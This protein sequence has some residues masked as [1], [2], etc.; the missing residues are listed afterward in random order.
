MPELPTGTVTFLFT[1][2][3]GSTKLW[4]EHP[5]AMR[6]VLAQHDTL[7][8]SCIESYG[9]HVFKTIG[10]AFCAVF[11]EPAGA[12]M[13]AIAAQQWLSALSLP[14]DG[15]GAPLKVRMALHSGV[16]E[17]RDGDYFGPVLNRIARLLALAHGGQVLL[18]EAA[19][20][21]VRDGLPPA[22]VLEPLGEHRLKDLGRPESI[23]Q[24]CHPDLQAGVLLLRSSSGVIRN[25]PQQP[26]AFVGREAEV[27]EWSREIRKRSHRLFT[28]VGL[29]GVGKTRVAVRLGESLAQEFPDGVWWCGL[30]DAADAH[31]AAEHLARALGVPLQPEPA[32]LAQVVRHLQGRQALLILDNVEQ[33]RG[34]PGLLKTLLAESRQLV[35]LVTSRR[36]LELRGETVLELAPMN[37]D[38]SVA[39]FRERASERRPDFELD[40][41]NEKDVRELCRRLEG[42]PLAIELAAARVGGMT[43]RQILQRLTERFRLLQS[44]SEEMNERQRALRGAID[45]SYALLNEDERLVFAQLSVFAGGFTLEDAEAVCEAFDVFETVMS[46]RQHSLFRV[47][48]VPGAQEQHFLM[49]ETLREYAAEKLAQFPDG[50]TAA[51]GRHAA[52]YLSLAREGLAKLRT[53][54]EATAFEQLARSESNLRAALDWVS[55]AGEALLECELAAVTGATLHRRG[56]LARAT[57][58]VEAGLRRARGIPGAPPAILAR[59]LLERAGFH[60]DH[61]D[62]GACDVLVREAIPLLER[63]GDRHGLARAENLLGQAAMARGDYDEAILRFGRA[64]EAF[65][66]VGDRIGIAI[67]LNNRGLMERGRTGDT[68]DTLDRQRQ[69]ADSLLQQSLALRR[70]LGDLRGIAETLTNLGVLAFE[71]E[72]FPQAWDFYR[73]ALSYEQRIG[74]FQGVGAA[75]A[76]LGEVAGR[77]GEAERGA[78]LLTVA[79]RTVVDVGSPLVEPV[80]AM[81]DEAAQGAGWTAAEL[82]SRRA[83]ARSGSLHDSWDAVITEPGQNGRR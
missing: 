57:E 16:A 11:G 82:A 28:L 13:A 65:E 62:P 72:Q 29:G 45:W 39:L 59:L 26:T 73:E 5:D 74:N 75:L 42:V 56:F 52:H 80:S 6:A 2:V 44:R 35:C 40:L 18:S 30:E 38:E 21:L 46:L 83:W 54:D 70:E 55:Q 34:G 71:R 79:E 81:L 19:R 33:I 23:F 25:L 48:L 7:L 1:D 77:L 49:L 4:E 20:A 60:C 12:V 3:E 76:N 10:D 31:D 68:P 43:P 69:L 24:L 32:V 51:H 8:R 15:G 36:T 27:E 9:G 78:I 67:A 66:L 50:G 41:E 37:V 64:C 47:E 58:V 22:A 53:P 17:E 63:D 61:G 14:S